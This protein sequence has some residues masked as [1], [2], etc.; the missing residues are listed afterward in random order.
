MLALA[1]RW[2]NWATH[3]CARKVITS[4]GRLK[5]VLASVAA[6]SIAATAAVLVHVVER[7]SAVKGRPLLQRA[8]V[9]VGPFGMTP[10]KRSDHHVANA[11]CSAGVRNADEINAH[12]SAVDG[13]RSSPDITAGRTTSWQ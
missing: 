8:H 5:S 12:G 3:N 4:G 9:V 11:S 10:R 6:D 2:I 13:V 7:C 1:L